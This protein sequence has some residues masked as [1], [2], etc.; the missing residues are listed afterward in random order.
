LLSAK[1]IVPDDNAA[2]ED[3]RIEQSLDD[4]L[5]TPKNYSWNFSIGRESR[6]A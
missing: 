4:T 6:E 3:Q 5:T 2:D 1:R